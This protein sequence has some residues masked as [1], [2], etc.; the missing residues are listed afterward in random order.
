MSLSDRF[1]LHA[2]GPF[3]RDFTD[4]LSVST[5]YET[6]HSLIQYTPLLSPTLQLQY[7][8]LVN[9]GIITQGFA[10][11]FASYRLDQL[12]LEKAIETLER[13]RA[14][15]WTKMCHL[16]APSDQLL[17]ADPDLGHKFVAVNRDLEALIKSVPPSHKL[18]MDDAAA[19]NLKAIDPFGHLLLKGRGLL[20]ERDT[21]ISHIQAFPA[22]T[23][24]WHL[25]PST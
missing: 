10:L 15:L 24:F 20:Q 13:G 21:L 23:A 9:H 22:S 16:R 17:D 3:W 6:T 4:T 5:A 19:D 11:D 14:F 18:S 8:T 12:Q 7:A 1:G 25:H 2:S